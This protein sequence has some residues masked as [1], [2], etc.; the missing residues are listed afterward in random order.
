MAGP[1]RNKTEEEQVKRTLTKSNPTD[2]D[3]LQYA[4]PARTRLTVGHVYQ[5][6][7]ASPT[8]PV[9]AWGRFKVKVLAVQGGYVTVKILIGGSKDKVRE[10]ALTEIQGVRET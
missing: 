8:S 3:G 10:I 4:D 2:Y 9:N 5:I 6:F 7:L 1:P